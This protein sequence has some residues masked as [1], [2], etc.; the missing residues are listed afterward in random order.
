MEPIEVNRKKGVALVLTA[1]I[2][3]SFA[4]L[5]VRLI[6]H[7]VEWQIL[8]YRSTTLV[9]FLCCYILV[10]RRGKFVA[11]IQDGGTL[12]IKAGFW[13]SLAFV[14][15]IYALTNTTVANALFMLSTAP[16]LAAIIG[17]LILKEVVLPSTWFFVALTTAGVGVMV[18][19]GLQLGTLFGTAMGLCAAIGF[20]LFAVQLRQGRQTDLVPFVLWAGFFASLW[21][22]AMILITSESFGISMR[23]WLLCASM[24]VFQVGV[25]LVIFS[26][27]SR[28]LS[29]AEI[30]LLS[31]TEIVLGP[32]W[33]WL[34]IKE[35]PGFLTLIGGGIV[36]SAIA[37]QAIR[38]L[39]Q[40]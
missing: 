5:A 27:G 4:G 17:R 8:F 29:A 7:A 32:L 36:M 26:H 20:A 14:A 23:D 30:T 25:G 13:L 31:M 2:F 10:A 1:G 38:T 34:V 24:G 40:I 16:F 15:W 6:E 12:A 28:H 21:A 35:M 33:V 39:R 19:E 11:S 18:V 9:G 37:G 3:W 22:G